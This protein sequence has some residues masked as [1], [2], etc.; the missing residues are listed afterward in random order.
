MAI[1]FA[2]EPKVQSEENPKGDSEEN[3]SQS[4][5]LW[6]NFRILM[7][8]TALVLFYFGGSGIVKKVTRGSDT[9]T[10]YF[11]VMG[12]ALAL[13]GADGDLGELIGHHSP[14]YAGIAGTTF[15]M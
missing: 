10:T 9:Y 8:A 5:K 14:T 1:H 2:C 7:A 3:L 13:F 11:I 15:A 6:K 4:Q 12:I